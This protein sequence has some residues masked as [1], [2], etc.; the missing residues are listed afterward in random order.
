MGCSTTAVR[1]AVNS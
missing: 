1:R